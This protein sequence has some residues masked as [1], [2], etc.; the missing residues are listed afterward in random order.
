MAIVAA[1]TGVPQGLRG[2]PVCAAVCRAAEIAIL[3]A[4]APAAP[5]PHQ[6][7]PL[8]GTLAPNAACVEQ[9]CQS[10]NRRAPM[11]HH[12]PSQLCHC[13][14]MRCTN[15]MMFIIRTTSYACSRSVS[16]VLVGSCACRQG[17][18]SSLATA[19]A[20]HVA[21]HQPQLRLYRFRMELQPLREPAAP[22]RIQYQCTRHSVTCGAAAVIYAFCLRS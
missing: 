10:L 9:A 18:S 13:I 15:V 17:S 3:A 14:M 7:Q 6:R 21:A 4:K 20:R 1:R 5:P 11:L 22:S 16:S 2:E 12:Q 8:V 19:D